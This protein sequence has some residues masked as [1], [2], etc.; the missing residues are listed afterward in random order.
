MK[1]SLK[2]LKEF[3]DVSAPP[4]KLAQELRGI[5]LNVESIESSGD[6]ILLD[7]EITTNRPDCLNHYGVAR[8]LAAARRTRLKPLKFKLKEASSPARNAASIKIADPKLCHRYCARVIRN[9]RIGPSPRWLAKRLEAVGVRTINNVTDVT[10]YVLME[11]GHPLHAFDLD[12]LREKKIIVR[13]ARNG[14]SLRTLDEEERKLTK[15]ALVIADAERPVALAGIMGGEETGISSGTQS[16]LLESAWFDP[17]S[18]RFTAKR[19][20]LRSEASYRFE[21][22][23]DI[24][25]APR[26]IDR[27]AELIAE[28]SGG[29]ILKG[30]LD[31]YPTRRRPPRI[32]LTEKDIGRL[33]GI[34]PARK[35]IE[36][37]LRGLEFQLGARSAGSWHVTPPS[38]RPDIHGTAD[39]VEE[40]ARHVGYDNLPSRLRPAPPRPER[41]TAREFDLRLYERLTGLGYAEIIAYPMVDPE[42]NA[43]FTDRPPVPLENPL[44]QEASVMR[45]SALPGMLRALKWN[46]DRDRKFLQLF[47]KG[48]TYTARPNRKGLPDERWVL[49]LGLTGERLSQSVHEKP[50]KADFFDL[51]GDIESLLGIYG[52]GSLDWQPGAPT[53]Y[54]PEL[55]ARLLT[56]GEN[57]GVCGQLNSTLENQYKLRQPAFVAEIDLERLITLGL[58][59]PRFSRFSR[60]PSVPRDFSLIVPDG[61][62]YGEIAQAI[63]QTGIGDIRSIQPLDHSIRPLDQ[64]PASEGVKSYSLLV[65]VTFQNRD[66][67]LTSDEVAQSSRKILDALEAISVRI[68]SA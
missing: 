54:N 26:A 56:R 40:V 53:H 5:G 3:V 66:R 8:E 35:E 21:R 42:E 67:T 37:I 28:L 27:A 31:V 17:V 12:R 64:F 32:S 14:E 62:R 20:G 1:I 63:E 22:G 25:M 61:T 51:K 38:F 57:L 60:F 47:E 48:K 49:T 45:S 55:S 58:T 65:R 9:V 59:T 7:I 33:L 41:D 44:S 68:R 36:R 15:D 34:Q 39:L 23:A 2:W 11:L 46:L 19:Q 6:G 24:E 29:E 30:I 13:R 16:V 50:R 18:I 4:Q 52:I 10:N 43:R